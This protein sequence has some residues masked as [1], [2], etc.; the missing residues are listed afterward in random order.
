MFFSLEKCT[1][2]QNYIPS[3]ESI[4][5]T[6]HRLIGTA[7]LLDKLKVSLLETYRANST[8]LRLEH[9]VSLAMVNMGI[10][11]RL[12]KLCHIWVN[13]IEEC[14]H[15]LY[16]WSSCFP[17]G[18]KIKEQ[19]PFEA[20]NNLKCDQDTLKLARSQYSNDLLAQKS[21]IQHKAHFESYLVNQT[22]VDK[23]KT[24]Q[25]EQG[26]KSNTMDFMDDLDFED[27]GGTH[28]TMILKY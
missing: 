19:Q 1:S 16:T 27:L 8:L 4:Q 10:C 15:M 20:Q 14:Y 2:K 21:S 25:K 24:I 17:S 22:I 7:L 13:Q 9:F 5:Y 18:L 3:K 28:N 23:V 26:I 12:Y 11:S 6:L